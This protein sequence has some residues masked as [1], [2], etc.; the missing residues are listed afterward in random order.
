VR[1]SLDRLEPVL[2]AQLNGVSGRTANASVN[3]L[4]Q[5]LELVLDFRLS[6]AS[7][8]GPVPRAVAVETE[9]DLADVAL[10]DLLT[11]L[12]GRTGSVA[13][14]GRPRDELGKT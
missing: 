2:D 9:R 6:L 7:D 10:V 11:A 1:V 13:A 14:A 4:A 8:A 12:P 5:L 3:L